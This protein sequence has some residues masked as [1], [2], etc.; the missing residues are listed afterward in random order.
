V[1]CFGF[2]ALLL[3]ALGVYGVVSYSVGQRT[4]EMGIRMVL[5]ARGQD[6]RH[7]VLRQGLAP[8][9]GGLAAGIAA[10]LGFGRLLGSFLFG[11]RAADPLTL[12]AVAAVVI[13]AT[14]A[15]CW[16]PARRATRVDPAV[17]LRCE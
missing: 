10:A 7:L 6:V 15:G 5:G 12:A 3:A 9:V 8:V 4:R 14:A 17:A 13:A 1:L 2:A 11:V 16:L